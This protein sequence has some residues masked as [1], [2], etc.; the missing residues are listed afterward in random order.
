MKNDSSML[1]HGQFYQTRRKA[2]AF[3]MGSVK[4]LSTP[5]KNR[6]LQESG[7]TM[8]FS[9]LYGNGASAYDPERSAGPSTLAGLIEDDRQIPGLLA[10]GDAV[11]IRHQ[12]LAILRTAQDNEVA[13]ARKMSLCHKRHYQFPIAKRIHDPLRL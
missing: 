6:S 3:A 7:V 13:A 9:R 8:D 2:P 1:R 5:M 10:A 12:D 11:W 4:A